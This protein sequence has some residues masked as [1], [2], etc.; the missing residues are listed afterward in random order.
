[1]PTP[2]MIPSPRKYFHFYKYEE[3]NLSNNRFITLQSYN[4]KTDITNRLLEIFNFVQSS[5]QPNEYV[6]PNDAGV[7]LDY[8]PAARSSDTI[9][10]E[11]LN[12]ALMSFASRMNSL[13]RENA[14]LQA[15]NEKLK[16]DLMEKMKEGKA[17]HSVGI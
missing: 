4:Q 2:M 14:K 11:D 1:M 8:M 5:L 3:L 15:E 13:D 9:S 17:G 10:E 6:N 7:L 16:E 12:T